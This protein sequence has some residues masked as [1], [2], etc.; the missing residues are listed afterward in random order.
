VQRQTEVS[1]T[2]AAAPVPGADADL[3]RYAFWP[4]ADSPAEA[5]A[6]TAIVL[7]GADR[8][9]DVVALVSEL[10][11][12]AVMH[13]AREAELH[14]VRR[15]GTIRVEV[16]DRDP[17]VPASPPTAGAHGGFGLRIVAAVADAWGCNP[18]DDGKRVWFEV[19]DPRD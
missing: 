15:R 13:T 19:R 18:L 14:I 16:R 8:L 5:R 4:T 11:T 6:R 3:L 12:N 10:V 9:D 7:A 2:P 1:R 17:R